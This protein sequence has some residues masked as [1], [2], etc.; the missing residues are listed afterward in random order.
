MSSEKNPFLSFDIGKFDV[1]K[2][3]ADFKVPG[4]DMEALLTAQK[5]NIAAL[6]EANQH[7]VAG[8]QAL[9]QRQVAIRAGFV[10]VV[11]R[12]CR[13][14][15]ARARA[16]EVLIHQNSVFSWTSHARSRPNRPVAAPS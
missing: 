1:Q 7:A 10:L 16:G 13:G 5:K 11:A 12:M 4:V 9:A 2:A 8:V 6:T 15:A 3:F 14:G